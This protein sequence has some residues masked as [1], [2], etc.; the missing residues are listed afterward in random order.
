[1]TCKYACVRDPD[2]V[3]RGTNLESVC[4]TAR[5]ILWSMDRVLQDEL[6]FFRRALALAW[7]RMLP[8]RYMVM[9]YSCLT[10]TVSSLPSSPA[11][12]SP[13]KTKRVQLFGEEGRGPEQSASAHVEHT[14][15][16]THRLTSLRWLLDTLNWDA[17]SL[18]KGPSRRS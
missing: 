3:P 8:N 9:R 10:Y 13:P 4:G 12:L 5:G 11:P 7:S 16:T 1:M 18:H 15:T 6:G 2:H 14:T 17:S